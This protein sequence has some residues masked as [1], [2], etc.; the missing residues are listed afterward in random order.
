MSDAQLEAVAAAYAG[1]LALGNTRRAGALAT[2]VSNP[3]RPGVWDANH[4]SLP[5][6]A[7][8]DAI[9]ELLAAADAHFAALD[10]EYFIVDALTPPAFEARLVQRGCLPSAELELLLEGELA[11]VRDVPGLEV[12]LAETD[13]DWETIGAMSRDEEVEEAAKF[14][15]EPRPAHVTRGLVAGRRDKGPDV[16]TWLARCE[17]V[18]CAHFSSWPGAAGVGKVEDLF[19]RPEFRHRGIASALIAH[20]VADA[21]ARGARA[22]LI[23]AMPEDTPRRMYEA[24]GF[25]PL[26]VMRGYQRSST[27]SAPSNAGA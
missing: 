1:Y 4:V 15:R 19:T 5:R 11:P 8:P 27:R 14:A 16:R 9:D 25:R 23:G 18:D 22:V 6:A 7:T 13:A 17:G 10:H 26:C 2:F 21:R 24:L 3:E 20:C 12:R